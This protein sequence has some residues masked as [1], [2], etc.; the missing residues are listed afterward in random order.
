MYLTPTHVQSCDHLVFSK[1]MDDEAHLIIL[2]PGQAL[3]SQ[4][5]PVL[6]GSTLHDA[7]VVDRQPAFADDLSE[8]QEVT[9]RAHMIQIN[10]Q[11]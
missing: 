7:D 2:E 10:Q 5:K 3:R 4:H 1:N 8:G 6:L 11:K 9:N